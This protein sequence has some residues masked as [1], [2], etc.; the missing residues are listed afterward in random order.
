M[1]E[2]EK[3]VSE[4]QKSHAIRCESAEMGGGHVTAVG[5]GSSSPRRRGI[6]LFTQDQHLPTM[7]A[8][9]VAEAQLIPLA[10]L[11]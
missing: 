7:S 9:P 11:V 6:S 1:R 4:I 5:L 8:P 3:V 10:V 2:K